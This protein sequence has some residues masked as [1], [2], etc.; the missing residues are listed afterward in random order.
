MRPRLG[1]DG[2]MRA[3]SAV[4]FVLVACDH[5]PARDEPPPSSPKTA[6][7]RVAADAASPDAAAPIDVAP[8]VVVPTQPAELQRWLASG[9]YKAWPAESKEHPSDGPHGDAVKTFVSPLLASSLAAGAHEHAK[10]AAAVKELYTKGKHS[11]WAVSVKVAD[12]SDAGRGWYW[13]EVFSTKP[14]AKPKY[15]GVGFELCRD[16]HAA[17]GTDLVLLPYPLQ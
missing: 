4:L 14:T 2:L 6:Q 3:V 12:A 8:A 15:A 5:R 17:G 11:G 10:G 1:D 13:Y 9:A 7:A 16:C